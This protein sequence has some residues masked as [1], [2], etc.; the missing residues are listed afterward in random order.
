MKEFNF[1]IKYSRWELLLQ[2]FFFGLLVI[3]VGTSVRTFSIQPEPNGLANYIDFT[4]LADPAINTILQVLLFIFS[5][6]YIWGKF[7][8]I[9]VGYMLFYLMALGTLL[10]SQG[11][12]SHGTQI[13]AL[14]LLGQFCAYCWYSLLKLRKQST[15]TTSN[16]TN[17]N[18]A[19]D[20]TQQTIAAAYVVAGIMKLISPIPVWRMG[21]PI[22]AGWI[23]D[24]PF[25]AVDIVRTHSQQYYNVLSVETLERGNTIANWIVSHPNLTRIIFSGGLF[26]EL[27]AFL[28]LL[29]RRWS[30]V[31]GISLILMHWGIFEIMQLK[32]DNNIYVLLIYTVNVPFLILSVN[33]LWKNNWQRKIVGQSSE[34]I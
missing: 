10:N 32:F 24:V 2:R 3:K 13:V 7:M 5:A 28:L 23:R 19:V 16:L 26:L 29:N 20:F 11:A 12:I 4:F 18:L 1:K 15:N 22:P 8:P 33:K 34:R 14:V 9:S 31:I 27:F 21:L 6:F 30:F 25:I 17:H